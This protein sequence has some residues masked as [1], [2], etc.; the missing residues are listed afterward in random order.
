MRKISVKEKTYKDL[1]RIKKELE[2][3]YKFYNKQKVTYSIAD[4]IDVLCASW[5]LKHVDRDKR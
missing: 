1:K 4:V 2:G 5:R 3:I